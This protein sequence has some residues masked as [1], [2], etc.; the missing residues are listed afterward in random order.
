MEKKV[1]IAH[2]IPNLGVG[3]AEKLVLDICNHINKNRFNVKIIS[4]YS[5]NNSV[6]EKIAKENNISIIFLNKKA[7]IDLKIIY[8]LIKIFRMEKINIIH[9]H[10]YV[11][12][13]VLIASLFCNIKHRIHT[14]HNM[15]DK[16]LSKNLRMIMKFGYKFFNV[17]PVAI[18]DYIKE[19]I[20]EE[21]K[22]SED[23][24]PCIY[25]GIDVKQFKE[26]Y[27]VQNKNMHLIHIGSFKKA[28]NH[29]MLINCFNI[30]AKENDKVKLFLVGD[31][32]LKNKI[33]DKVKKLQL[34]DKVIFRGIQKD[35]VNEL[36]SANIF[37]LS[38]DYEGVPICI[39][40]AMACGLPIVTTN[41]GGVIDII[42]NNKNGIIVEKGN[43]LQMSDEIKKLIYDENKRSELG[44]QARNDAKKYDIR[45]VAKQY[46]Q[47][48]LKIYSKNKGVYK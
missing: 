1:N 9:T 4:L 22:I 12:P 30:I 21:Y 47:L 17:I 48:Y 44:R 13:Y 5:S 39:L 7:G 31:G 42:E 34:E 40:E 45:I 8:Q 15:A 27:D 37:V 33:V 11:M 41:A 26:K 10:L 14:V 3:G 25:N 29:S 35:I 6:Y 46:E 36:H 24:I 32:E 2:I 23:K 43:Y 18:S 20:I 38:S 19:T 16:E 28:K